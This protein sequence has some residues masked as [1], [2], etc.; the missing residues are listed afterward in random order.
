MY[1]W[2]MW[3]HPVSR[4]ALRRSQVQTQVGLLIFLVVLTLVLSFSYGLSFLWLFIGVSACAGVILPSVSAF[5]VVNL[6]MVLPVAISLLELGSIAR[7]NWPLTL[8]L[9]LLI[10][11]LGLDMIGA[12]RMGRT[13]RDL[14]GARRELARLAVAEERLRMARDL[15]DVLGHTLSM[16]ALKSELAWRTMEQEP[17]QAA[18]EMQDVEK[19][20]R[21]LLREVRTAVAGYRQPTLQGELEGAQQLLEAAGIEYHV[22]MA[23]HELPAPVDAVLAWVVREGVTNVVRHSRAR[24]CSLSLTDTPEWV[25]LVITNDDRRSTLPPMDQSSSATGSGLSGIVERV[26]AQGG[27][28]EAGPRVADG[29]AGFRVKVEL[30]LLRCTADQAPWTAATPPAAVTR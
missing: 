9:A 18:H 20:T 11:A 24:H 14:H 12:A 1:T 22:E 13:F 26:M 4:A 27:H 19:A 7:V 25:R 15:H 30:P 2:L 5:V 8:A 17:Q 6:L 23:A 21:Q 16:I 3:P 10:R 28:I 29:M